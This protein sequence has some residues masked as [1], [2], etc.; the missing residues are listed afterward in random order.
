MIY[1]ITGFIDRD[2]PVITRGKREKAG[3]AAELVDMEGVAD[4]H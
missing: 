2:S 3:E 4:H 1:H